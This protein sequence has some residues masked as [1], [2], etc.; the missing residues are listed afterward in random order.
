MHDFPI[1]PAH[2]ASTSRLRGA[3][4]V[5]IV[6]L[7]CAA[8]PAGQAR[9]QPAGALAAASTAAPDAAYQSQVRAHLERHKRFPTAK[10]YDGQNGE[11]VI[12]FSIDGRGRVV[13]VTTMRSSGSTVYDRESEAMVRRASPYPRPPNGQSLTFSIP[14]NFTNPKYKAVARAHLIR[15]LRAA[16]GPSLPSGLHNGSIIFTLDGQGRVMNAMIEKTSGVDNVDALLL[17]IVRRASPFPAPPNGQQATFTQPIGFHDRR[18]FGF[19]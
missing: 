3:A 5:I 11:A 16:R 4:L 12:T 7:A 15:H 18:F 14:V 1:I 10:R 2:S 8:L 6:A 17:A 9:S 13:S 19:R